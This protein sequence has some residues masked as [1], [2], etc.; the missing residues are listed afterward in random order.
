LDITFDDGDLQEQLTSF[1]QEW[2]DWRDL[3]PDIAEIVRSSIEENFL[4]GGRYGRRENGEWTGG[5]NRWVPSKRARRTGGST[6]QDQGLLAGSVDVSWN[7]DTLVMSSNVRYAA[8]HQYGV[9]INHPGG[10]PYLPFPEGGGFRRKDGSSG[11]MIFLRKD[12]AYPP[13][14]EFTKA[15]IIVLA[16]RPFLVIQTEDYSD[17]V[18]LFITRG[19]GL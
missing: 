15:H 6:L 16:A 9:K 3:R 18:E 7:G 13:G 11:Q 12:G 4:Q 5:N 8:A 2:L 17:I 14:V 19:R 10:T 1:L